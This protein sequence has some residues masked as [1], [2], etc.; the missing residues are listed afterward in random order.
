MAKFS[1]IY[2][3]KKKVIPDR[4]KASLQKLRWNYLF[5]FENFIYV[6]DLQRE[7]PAEHF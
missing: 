5:N 7:V 3:F 2:F 6:L 4:W 1:F